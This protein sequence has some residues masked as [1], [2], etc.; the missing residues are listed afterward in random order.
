M[1]RPMEAFKEPK[2]PK[3]KDTSEKIVKEEPIEDRSDAVFVD[4]ET[5]LKNK[6]RSQVNASVPAPV[7]EDEVQE[8]SSS[9]SNDFEKPSSPDR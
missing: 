2:M 6:S 4:L 9:P 8:V 3:R 1:S 5:P 7:S